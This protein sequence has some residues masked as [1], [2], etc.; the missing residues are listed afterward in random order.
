[1]TVLYMSVTLQCVC[2]CVCLCVYGGG[3]R[4][5]HMDWP[6]ASFHANSHSGHSKPKPAPDPHELCVGAAGETSLVNS[7]LH[8][9]PMFPAV[10]SSHATQQDWLCY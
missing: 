2:A 5:A 8:S 1:M 10:A 7:P 9:V 6:P 4:G 3:L